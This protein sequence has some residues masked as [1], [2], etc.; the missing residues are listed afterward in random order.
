MYLHKYVLVIADDLSSNNWFVPREIVDAET[1]AA[2]I[3]RRI[4]IFTVM[5]NT[6]WATKAF[7]L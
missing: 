5:H 6:G 2:E 3:S 1:V 4:R 7:T